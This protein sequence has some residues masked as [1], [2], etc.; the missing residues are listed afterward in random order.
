MRRL[1]PTLAL[2]AAAALPAQGE[3]LRVDFH[4]VTTQV[5]TFTSPEPFDAAGVASESYAIDGWMLVDTDQPPIPRSDGLSFPV[6]DFE[7]VARRYDGA[8]AEPIVITPDNAG[9][10]VS[11]LPST[12]GVRFFA[13]NVSTS[14]SYS[15]PWT[16]TIFSGSMPSLPDLPGDYAVSGNAIDSVTCEF[17]PPTGTTTDCTWDRDNGGHDLWK[18]IRYH[19]RTTTAPDPEPCGPADIDGNGILNFDDIDAFVDGFLGG[20]NP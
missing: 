9:A 5:L 4:T 14:F 13:G 16:A 10:S 6:A 15:I 8:G 18:Y 12:R 1:I 3:W 2:L 11:V 19:V 7:I 20:C 17:T